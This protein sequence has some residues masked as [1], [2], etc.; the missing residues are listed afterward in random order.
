MGNTKVKSKAKN[1]MF[2]AVR[3]NTELCDYAVKISIHLSELQITVNSRSLQGQCLTKICPM[4]ED[5][6]PAVGL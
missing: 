5:I 2:I 3:Q 6:L 1:R 4:S